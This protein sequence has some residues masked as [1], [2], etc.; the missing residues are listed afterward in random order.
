MRKPALSIGLLAAGGLLLLLTAGRTWSSGAAGALTG[1]ELAT[2]LDPISWLALAAAALLLLL[3]G[4]AAR[5]VGAL[6][7]IAGL[8][9]LVE[10]LAGEGTTAWRWAAVAGALL[11]AAG[12][13]TAAAG[14]V[15]RAG[16][17]AATADQ[18]RQDAWSALDR[19]ED[20]TVDPDDLTE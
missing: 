3:G 1:R 18:G 10:L 7:A 15:R 20:P 4:A 9:L 16:S 19:G 6:V 5:L 11:I 17:P 2:L 14:A 8:T 13:V 12:G